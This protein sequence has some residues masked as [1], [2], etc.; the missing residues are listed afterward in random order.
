MSFRR[1]RGLSCTTY[2]AVIEPTK[3][4]MPYVDGFV[5]PVRKDR[6]DEYRRS[7]AMRRRSGWSMER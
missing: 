3:I 2:G 5:I 7:P 4:G 1:P 6:I